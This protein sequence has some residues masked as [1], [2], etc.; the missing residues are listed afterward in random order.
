MES[1]FCAPEGGYPETL[2]YS[3]PELL[4]LRAYGALQSLLWADVV[5]RHDPCL[6]AIFNDLKAGIAGMGW[7]T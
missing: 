3:S 7:R 5:A 4:I 1:E 2:P 6:V